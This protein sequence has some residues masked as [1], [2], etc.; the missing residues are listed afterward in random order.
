MDEDLEEY[1]LSADH[2]E[3]CQYRTEWNEPQ[4]WGDTTA[5]ESF[6][7]CTATHNEQC[8]AYAEWR[9]YD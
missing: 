1:A 6:S 7:E 4:P 9:M 3:G 2:C 8:P 5:S